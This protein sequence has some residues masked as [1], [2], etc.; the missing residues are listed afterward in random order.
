MILAPVA[1]L[2]SD[3]PVN[4]PPADAPA[5]EVERIVSPESAISMEDGVV[6]VDLP[7]L[8]P[9][10]IAADS[11]HRAETLTDARLGLPAGPITAGERSKLEM[12]RA[13]I[14][15][16]RA[17]GTLF[18]TALPEDTVPATEAE[19]AAMKMQMLE[20]RTSVPPAADPAAGV[21]PNLPSVQEVGPSGLTEYE[22][23]KLRGENP[24]PPVQQESAPSEEARA[25]DGA[26]SS[27][28]NN[29]SEAA[30]SAAKKESSNE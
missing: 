23:A 16:S 26:P 7:S 19:L 8:Q 10:P 29:S 4:Q 3:D 30:T 2:A 25:G 15:A 28:E 11:E 17:A 24:P 27:D 13:A 20:A 12:A 18:I 14:E 22:E 5:Q 21:G 9:T 6:E 1:A